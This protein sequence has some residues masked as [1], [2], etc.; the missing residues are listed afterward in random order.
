MSM[1]MHSG[2]CK[3]KK[4]A[5]QWLGV[6]SRPGRCQ[7]GQLCHGGSQGGP[8]TWP[9]SRVE[10]RGD[11][12]GWRGPTDS[13]RTWLG[14]QKMDRN[15]DGVVTMDEFL[16]TCQKVG[17]HQELRTPRVLPLPVPEPLPTSRHHVHTFV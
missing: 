8:F 14:L 9:G 11:R 12:S 16:E 7:R 1:G 5:G 2:K 6:G 10:D 13:L 4:T 17:G 3:P 15:Q